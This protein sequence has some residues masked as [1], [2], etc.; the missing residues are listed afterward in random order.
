MGDSLGSV[1]S[2]RRH[3]GATV[4]LYQTSRGVSTPKASPDPVAR[5]IL[6]ARHEQ[7][8]NHQKLIATRNRIRMLENVQLQ[9]AKT[10]EHQR[11]TAA[12]LSSIRERQKMEVIAR[13]KVKAERQ[14]EQL[15]TRIRLLRDKQERSM[16]ISAARSRVLSE[17]RET[18]EN[19]KRVS[20]QLDVTIESQRDMERQRNADRRRIIVAESSKTRQER[21]LSAESQREMLKTQ[22][23]HRLELE[24]KRAEEEAQSFFTL[25]KELEDRQVLP[26]SKA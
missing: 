17:K 19:I 2:T 26:N 7:V 5:E 10:A 16:L 12:F 1:L 11:R 24:Q 14:T 21:I 4:S 6:R 22:Y 20:E 9:S 8:Q 18:V 15:C 13:D 3:Q 25:Q 23:R